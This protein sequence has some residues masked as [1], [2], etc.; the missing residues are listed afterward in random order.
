[1]TDL[2]QIAALLKQQQQ[3]LDTLVKR[4][5]LPGPILTTGE[6]TAYTKHE[7][8][9]AFYRWCGKWRVTRTANGRYSRAHLDRALDRE[10][11]TRRARKQAA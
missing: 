1:M 8:D 9:S 4:A 11:Q 10:A 3:Q 7:S 6:A 2:E 5:P